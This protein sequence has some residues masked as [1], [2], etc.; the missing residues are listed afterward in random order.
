[1]FFL[2]FT[3]WPAYGR[4]GRENIVLR[5]WVPRFPLIFEALHIKLNATT[6]PYLIFLSPK[7]ES[8]RQLSRLQSHSCATTT[9]TYYVSNTYLIQLLVYNTYKYIKNQNPSK[10]TKLT[11]TQVNSFTKSSLYVGAK[12]EML[13]CGI[14]VLNT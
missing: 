14:I 12:S 4:L 13:G 11:H 8:N 9:F 1:M 2:R 7:W 5:N 10:H 3:L 6:I